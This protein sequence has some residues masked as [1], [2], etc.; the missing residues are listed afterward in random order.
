VRILPTLKCGL[1]QRN[2]TEKLYLQLKEKTFD[3]IKNTLQLKQ[4]K[5]LV[6]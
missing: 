1:L 5:D 6:P 4:K 3:S 2:K